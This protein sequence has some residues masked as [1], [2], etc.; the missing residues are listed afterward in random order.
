MSVHPDSPGLL[1]PAFHPVR[2][3]MDLPARSQGGAFWHTRITAL[4]S[5]HE[6]RSTRQAYPVRQWQFGPGVLEAGALDHLVRFFDAR[7]GRLHGFLFADPLLSGSVH[8][9]DQCVADGVSPDVQLVRE[10]GDAI[11][12]L[13][14]PVHKPR[15]STV[16]I[17]VDDQRQD[18]G[19]SLEPHT[20][21]VVFASPPPDGAMIRASFEFDLPVRFDVDQ[22]EI[23]PV[24]RGAGRVSGLSL[25]ELRG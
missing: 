11:A 3:E 23:Q 10:A 4:A 1:P 2:L 7:R 25:V 9:A 12:P 17:Y 8:R 24:G 13:R 6:A 16:Q 22:L 21:R 5:G 20:G 15:A 18:T 19:W 14:L